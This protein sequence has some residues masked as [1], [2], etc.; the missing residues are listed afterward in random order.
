MFSSEVIAGIKAHAR[1]AWPEE[2]CGIVA[3]S[4]YVPVVNRH[5]KPT[6]H[7]R[8]EPDEYLP[9][10]LGQ[11]QAI[12]HSHTNDKDWPSVADQEEQ[13]RSK[14]PWGI[15]VARKDWVSEPFWFGDQAP[16]P[17]LKQRHFRHAVTDCYGLL[18]DWFR[19][20]RK[21]T[22]PNFVRDEDW[23]EKGQNLLIDNFGLAG[24]VEIDP[25]VL[26]RGDV[27][28][29]RVVSKYVNHCGVYLGDGMIFHHLP[30][31]PSRLDMLGPWK[32]LITHYLRYVGC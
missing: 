16:I 6:E 3:H 21:V 14:L 31:R 7:F 9:L 18:R 22:L 32:K 4:E 28:L 1:R 19:V 10:A 26:K 17:P 25:A 29:G 30:G 12:V 13:M 20:H 2:C 24:F 23:W 8:M 5:P 11:L 15:L 27:V